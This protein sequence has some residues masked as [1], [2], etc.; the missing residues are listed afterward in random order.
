MKT[1]N[2]LHFCHTSQKCIAL[3]HEPTE[4]HSS[5]AQN[6]SMCPFRN[7]FV[8]KFPQDTWNQSAAVTAVMVFFMPLLIAHGILLTNM[9]QF[10]AKNK[11][12]EEY[13]L[14]QFNA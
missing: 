7:D 1:L 5:T 13:N 3:A 6:P 12:E 2:P 9:L 4:N 11:T 10:K 14:E 8:K